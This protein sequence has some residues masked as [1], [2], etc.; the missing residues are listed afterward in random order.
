VSVSDLPNPLTPA[1]CDL[2]DFGYM[3]V[4]VQ[5][6][7]D[8][9]LAALESPE[10]CW[11]A[12]LLWC[13]SWHQVPAASLPDDDRVLAKF[14]GYQR[15]PEAWAAIREGAMRG[16]IKCTDGRLY[17]PVVA[18][19]ANEAWFAKHRRAHDQLCERVR[20]RNKSRTEAGLNPLEVPP[21]D[22]W[23]DMGRPLEKAL[24]PSEF[25]TPSSGKQKNSAKPV[26]S[27]NGSADDFHRNDGE[28]PAE[29]S[30]KGE[31]R[32]GEGEGEGEVNLKPIGIIGG[33]GTPPCKGEKEP[34]AA[35]QISTAL[36]GWERQRHKAAR[37]L[38]PS[39]QQVIDLA[40]MHVTSAE[41]RAAYECAVADRLATEDPNPVNAG[42]IAVFVNKIRNPPKPRPKADDWYRTNPGIERKASEL[43]IVCPPGK[44]H[45][46]L[47]ERCESEIRK[48]AQGVAA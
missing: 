27:S 32:N 20:K 17:H 16:W 7:C 42:F 31:E 43:G 47:R 10:A 39:N 19:K 18:E 29:N 28:I 21:L 44:D 38:T 12:F 46:W 2:R 36:I 35:A 34:L 1:D 48:R 3:P 24:F 45:G 4:D 5:R 40:D 26:Q 6:V 8:S 13:K 23:I 25:S 9:D 11:A 30:L 37:G 41:L 33:S 22:H 15:A 14:T